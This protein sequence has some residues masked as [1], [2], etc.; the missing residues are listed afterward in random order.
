MDEVSIKES[1]NSE[2]SYL[3]IL[4]NLRNTS[5]ISISNLVLYCSGNIFLVE[6]NLIQSG[7]NLNLIPTGLW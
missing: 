5:L 7:I 1:N 6:V 3:V 2:S 4:C